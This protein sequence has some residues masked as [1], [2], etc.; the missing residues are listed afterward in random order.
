MIAVYFV[1]FLSRNAALTVMAWVP[2]LF[3]CEDD[4]ASGDRSYL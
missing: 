3:E 2:A 4:E 1:K